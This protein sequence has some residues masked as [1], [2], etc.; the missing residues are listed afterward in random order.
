[1]EDCTKGGTVNSTKME[2]EMVQKVFT[3]KYTNKLGFYRCMKRYTY[4]R[5]KKRSDVYRPDLVW[6]KVGYIPSTN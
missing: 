5:Q 4:S 6:L 2:K 1:M 3:E